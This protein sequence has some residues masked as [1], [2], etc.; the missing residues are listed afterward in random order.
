MK[1]LNEIFDKV[2]VLTIPSF[3]DRIE[4]MKQR[5]E[6]VDYEFFYGAYGRD[7]DVEYYRSKGSRLTRGQLGCALSHYR[8][9]EKIVEEN[10]QNVLIL[11]DDCGFHENIVELEEYYS[12]LPDD[13]SVFYLGYDCPFFESYSPKLTIATGNVGYTHSMNVKKDCA[14]KMLEVNENLLWT[15]D[16]A[17]AQLHNTHGSK[18]YLANPKLTYQDNDGTTSTLVEVDKKYGMGL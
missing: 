3:T 11:E 9:Y 8:I 5:L 10:L 14:E 17:F 1:I 2:L 15:A 16:G 13:Y 7:I 6:G 4:N 12:Q 18:Y